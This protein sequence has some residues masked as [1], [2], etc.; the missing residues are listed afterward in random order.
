MTRCTIL[1]ITLLA[2]PAAFAQY[3]LEELPDDL[4][5]DFRAMRAEVESEPGALADVIKAGR[6]RAIFCNT[7]HGDDGNAERP[8]YPAL[9]GQ[10]AAYLLDQI[11]QFAAGTREKKVM[12]VLAATFSNAEKVTLA[13]YYSHM[14]RE[15]PQIDADLAQSGAAQY[16]LRCAQCH[17]ADGRGQQGYARIAGQQPEYV[18]KVLREYRGGESPRRLSPM[19][20]VAAA[21]DDSVIDAIAHY[22][23]SLR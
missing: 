5:A 20:G 11:E 8:T 21:L 9:A 22:A 23:A 2:A 18:A 19:Y 15:Q 16:Q 13:L 3:G 4:V 10:N 1:L 6:E 7:C 17:G 12:N 14:E